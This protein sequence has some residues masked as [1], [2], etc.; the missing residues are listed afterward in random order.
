M[1]Q[2]FRYRRIPNSSLST[3]QPPDWWQPLGLVRNMLDAWAS[4]TYDTK[5]GLVCVWDAGGHGDGAINAFLTRDLKEGSSWTIVEQ[6]SPPEMVVSNVAWF[7]DGKP[8]VPHPYHYR[9]YSEKL[10]R[11]LQMG[12]C[13]VHGGGNYHFP[14]I[15]GFDPNVGRY[16]P[17][18]TYADC[19]IRVV[20]DRICWVD[21]R[22][23][24]Y[25]YW[26]DSTVVRWNVAAE[27]RDTPEPWTVVRKFPNAGPRGIAG[28]AAVDTKRGRVLYA[29]NKSGVL[30]WLQ[31]PNLENGLT[32][33]V[34]SAAEEFMHD[35]IVL[36][37]G[38]G[39]CMQYS[40]FADA[41]L[42]RNKWAGGKVYR[43]KPSED[44]SEVEITLPQTEGGE[45]IPE[46]HTCYNKFPPLDAEGKSFVYVTRYE[47]DLYVMD[48]VE[49]G[50][51]PTPEPDPK[52]VPE[53][54][55]EPEDPPVPPQEGTI[56][57][58]ALTSAAPPGRHPFM[59]GQPF[60]EGEVV[61]VEVNIPSAQ[62]KINCRWND[63]S[64]KHATV[65]G[66][67]EFA[68]A[69]VDVV[70]SHGTQARTGPDLTAADIQ[71]ANPQA[72]IECLDVVNNGT[73]EGDFALELQSLLANPVKTFISGPEMIECHYAAMVGEHPQLHG[74]FHVRLYKSGRMFVRAV[75]ENGFLDNAAGTAKDDNIGYIYTPRIT[76]D[77]TVAFTFVDPVFPEGMV[78]K[79]RGR[80]QAE[81]WIGGDPI[82][83][84]RHDTPYAIKTKLFPNQW[85]VGEPT[86]EA[87]MHAVLDNKGMPESYAVVEPGRNYLHTGGVPAA[88]GTA[89]FEYSIAVIKNWSALYLCN[90]GH[91]R[92]FRVMEACD[93]HLQHRPIFW[94]SRKTWKVPRPNNYPNWNAAG[95]NGGGSEVK[96]AGAGGGWTQSHHPE[97][98]YASYIFTGD[99]KHLEAMQFNAISNW[100]FVPASRGDGTSR[101]AISAASVQDRGAAW[102][103][104]TVAA[105][106]AV[107]PDGDDD[108]FRDQMRTWFNYVISY[109]HALQHSPGMPEELGNDW[110]MRPTISFDSFMQHYRVM[111]HCFAVEVQPVGAEDMVKLR[112]HAIRHARLIV[113]RCGDAT[114][115]CYKNYPLQFVFT[116]PKGTGLVPG[117]HEPI[118]LSKTDNLN[119]HAAN[120]TYKTWAEIWEHSQAYWD[121]LGYGTTPDCPENGPLIER[122]GRAHISSAPKN[123]WGEAMGALGYAVNIGV[124]DAD[125]AWARI[126]SAP[127]WNMIAQIG[128]K[129]RDSFYGTPQYGIVPRG[130]WNA[131]EE[132]PE[133]P[134]V[135]PEEPEEPDPISE[136]DQL[137]AQIEE[138]S[139]ELAAASDEYA[140]LEAEVQALTVELRVTTVALED[141]RGKVERVISAITDL[142]GA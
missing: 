94:R 134:E 106:L 108:E 19:P 34:G 136:V 79:G 68:G 50:E 27:G 121:G 91:P 4:I 29:G 129:S 71:A 109:L 140:V 93:S 31:L 100:L 90:L 115:F 66:E 26:N 55:P 62:V 96:G 103:I 120:W 88:M 32:T 56:V 30:L 35:S 105:Y 28:A 60:V 78:H 124:P 123:R 17:E 116:E 114:G 58:V 131:S 73:Q 22:T 67:T 127:N 107:A 138:L 82:I 98:G 76:I 3:L 24:H 16:E 11:H 51:Q 44:Y 52:P 74:R 87:A 6:P 89:G 99:Y 15:V 112:E 92:A 13:A 23:E 85:H 20:P 14:V 118:T 9:W 133:D 102:L 7:L 1:T 128:S 2:T 49:D 59:I 21:P 80:P 61:D 10:D 117:L 119:M 65:C 75:V 113:G 69:P 110:V 125:K 70:F 63:G 38:M 47:A 137:K 43:L 5:R 48:I 53:P 95:P 36:R 18:G 40:A 132:P 46:S 141:L 37:K 8:S 101:S 64:V 41:F 126:T 42:L 97:I 72:L 57:S 39:H 12:L 135:P 142:S 83:T 86:N 81:R 111:A 122:F 104:R 25:Y 130:W 33:A 54:E 45:D 84:P 139:A 77:G